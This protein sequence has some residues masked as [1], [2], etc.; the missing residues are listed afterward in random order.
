[1]GKPAGRVRG[2]DLNRGEIKLEGIQQIYDR[3]DFYH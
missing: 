2:I 1:M 3:L